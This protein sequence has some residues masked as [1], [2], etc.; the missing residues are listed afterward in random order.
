MVVWLAWSTLVDVADQT[1]EG[2]LLSE[3]IGMVVI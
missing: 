3:Q 1:H 2:N